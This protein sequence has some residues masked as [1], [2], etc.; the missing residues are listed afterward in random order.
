MT[1]LQQ[2]RVIE[3]QRD[4]PVRGRYDVLVAGGGLGG[5][6]SALAAARCGARTLLVE[7]N[8]FVGGVATAGMCCSIFNCYYTGRG[9][10]GTTGIAVEVADALAEAAPAGKG[11]DQA[12]ASSEG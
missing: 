7:R 8:G 11:A 10:L 6:A 3:P 5:V 9:V 4:L 12:S 2:N 1:L